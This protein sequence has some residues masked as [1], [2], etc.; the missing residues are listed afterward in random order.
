MRNECLYPFVKAHLFSK[1]FGAAAWRAAQ[2]PVQRGGAQAGGH[3]RG[4]PEQHGGPAGARGLG[5][6]RAPPEAAHPPGAP[7]APTLNITCQA[8]RGAAPVLSRAAP[9]PGRPARVDCAHAHALACLRCCC[10]AALRPCRRAQ[11]QQGGAACELWWACAR[12]ARAGSRP[13]LARSSCAWWTAIRSRCCLWR[14]L[15]RGPGRSCT[16]TTPRCASP[17]RGAPGDPHAQG[18]E[19]HPLSGALAA[20][21]GR[22]RRAPCRPPPARARMPRLQRRQRAALVKALLFT[23]WADGGMHAGGPGLDKP[24]IVGQPFWD[25]FSLRSSQ[26]RPHV[27]AAALS[28]CYGRGLVRVW[29]SGAHLGVL[30]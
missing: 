27:T 7:P 10:A 19:W 29:S 15:L 20:L 3:E 18:T 23:G 6:V 16:R 4:H 30:L 22:W 25:V 9:C 12:P 5:R 13:L 24:G 26:V 2:G 21:G 1:R 11:P 28:P 17:V 8:A 14:R